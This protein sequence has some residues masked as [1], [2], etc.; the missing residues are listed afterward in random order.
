LNL[1]PDQRGLIHENDAQSLRQFGE[2]VR[3][4]FKENLAAGA[5][6]KASNVRK[7]DPKFAPEQ[8][9]DA[10]PETYWTTDDWTPSAE[11]IYELPQPRRFNRALLQEQIR[12]GQRI[13]AFALDT[14]A[15]DAW[16]EIARATTVGHKRLLRFDAVTS[17]KVRLRLTQ[18]RVAPTLANFGLYLEQR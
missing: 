2:V 13:E 18:F 16:Q 9:A 15:G 5:K 12:V 7:N 1:P 6:A 10:D 17:D 8:S 11:I 4:T 14:W 3:R